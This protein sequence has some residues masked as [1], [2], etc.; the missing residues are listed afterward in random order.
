MSVKDR[1]AKRSIIS[2]QRWLFCLLVFVAEDLLSTL[3]TSH[4]VLLLLAE[5]TGSQLFGLLGRLYLIALK[6]H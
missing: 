5:L 1:F 4:T 6:R 3:A 2:V